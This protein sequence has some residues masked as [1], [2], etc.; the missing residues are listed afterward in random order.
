MEAIAQAVNTYGFTIVLVAVLIYLVYQI[1]MHKLELKKKENEAK[2]EA[3][4][5]QEE[6]EREAERQEKENQ[7]DAMI[8][9][10][11]KQLAETI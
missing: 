8:L 1:V 2:I 10:K 11:F 9:E 6:T 4:K 3:I 7:R 5:K